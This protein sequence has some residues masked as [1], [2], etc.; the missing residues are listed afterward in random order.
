MLAILIDATNRAHALFYAGE[1]E[2][3]EALRA[4]VDAWR[5]K[6]KAT[7]TALVFDGD[8]AS[9][10]RR[11]LWPGYKANRKQ[12]AEAKKAV[13]AARAK[14]FLTGETVLCLD[15]E[16]ADD[17]LFSL[18]RHVVRANGRAVVLSTDG[19]MAQ[20]L[21]PG[22]V[23]LCRRWSR[24]AHGLMP[25]FVTASAWEEEHGVALSKVV[26]Y[27]CLVGDK[28]DGLEGLEGVG[29]K[30]AAALLRDVAGLDAIVGVPDSLTPKA[31][32]KWCVF[33][34]DLP[35]LRQVVALREIAP[36]ELFRTETGCVWDRSW[37]PLRR[38]G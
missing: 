22:K 9:E 20:C 13:A 8:G 30:R 16:E 32:E 23:S 18:S 25:E 7:H 36:V 12:N 10:W 4:D 15:G 3:A 5:A 29:E 31:R 27:R 21:V 35:T 17:V 34:D 38:I 28:S 26:D 37:E 6:Y 33:M 19:D 1:T 24:G 14:V 2:I 11:S